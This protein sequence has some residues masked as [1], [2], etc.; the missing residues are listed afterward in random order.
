MMNSSMEPVSGM[1]TGPTPDVERPMPMGGDSNDPVL[2]G[3]GMDLSGMDD[4]G[5]S[6]QS[7][8]SAVIEWIM[9]PMG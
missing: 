6:S 2:G 5:G 9:T 4:V 1:A 7:Y 8:R 3:A